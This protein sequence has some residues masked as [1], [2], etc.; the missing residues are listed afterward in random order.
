MKIRLIIDAKKYMILYYLQ[1]KI[2][3]NYVAG[4]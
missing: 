3:C 1:Y 2:L 4:G